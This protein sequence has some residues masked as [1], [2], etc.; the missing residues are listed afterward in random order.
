[1]N[2]QTE[3]IDVYCR[4]L[5]LDGLAERFETIAS[6]A[7]EQNWSFLEFLEQAL[8]HER[9]A[10]QVRSRQM[11]ARMACFPVIKMLE[12]YDFEFAS[13]TPKNLIEELAML[14][15]IERG[16]NAVFLGPSEP[17][18]HCSSSR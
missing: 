1:M 16:E 7:A 14:R 5:K 11:L 18:T 9:D 2:L 4:Q 6:K 13:G 10:R 17:A 15:F 12:Q 3:R 8:T